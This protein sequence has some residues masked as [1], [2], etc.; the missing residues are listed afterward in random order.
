MIRLY[1][2][3]QITQLKI[4]SKCVLKTTRKICLTN[5]DSDYL[6]VNEYYKKLKEVSDSEL[7]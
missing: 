4:V 6:L 3:F 2:N 5:I 7:E 1:L